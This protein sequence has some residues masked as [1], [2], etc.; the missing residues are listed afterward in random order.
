MRHVS[1][2]ISRQTYKS[3]ATFESVQNVQNME[4]EDPIH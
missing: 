3:D 1:S 2:S 4:E